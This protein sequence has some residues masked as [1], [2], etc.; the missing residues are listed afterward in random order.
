M[1][2]IIELIVVVTLLIF[3]FVIG[4]KYSE[5]VKSHASWLFESKE[6]EVDLPD[7][8]NENNADESTIYDGGAAENGDQMPEAT[9]N[10]VTMD[11]GSEIETPTSEKAT[12]AAADSAKKALPSKQ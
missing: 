4:V 7:L 8:T 6:E 5:N 11:N 1:T 3:S 2:K 12:P 9:D 10:S